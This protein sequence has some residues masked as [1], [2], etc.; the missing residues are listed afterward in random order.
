M[1]MDL[2]EW[3]KN[4]KILVFHVNI[5]QRLTSKEESFN[6]QVSG[7]LCAYQSAFIPSQSYHHPIGLRE[8]MAMLA[9]MEVMHRVNSTN[10]H[11][12]RVTWSHLFLSAQSTSSRDQH[13]VLIGTI[14]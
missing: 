13:C 8:K 4:K 5:H 7:M 14:S 2:F 6:N 9:E 3:A 1:W 10:F 11:F 12:L